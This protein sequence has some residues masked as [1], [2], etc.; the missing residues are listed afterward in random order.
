MRTTVA[1][2]LIGRHLA[3]LLH[4]GLRLLARFLGE[5]GLAD[6]LFEFVELVAAFFAFAELLLDRLELLVQ[7]I[8]ALRLLHLALDAASDLA[9]DLQHADLGF[10]QRE[11]ASPAARPCSAFRAAAW[12]S[13]IFTD[14]CEATVSASF[15]GSSICATEASVSAGTFL[16]SLM[17]CSKLVLTV[18]ISASVSLASPTLSGM[19]SIVAWKKS[20]ARHEAG[21]AGARLAF[22]QHAHGLVGQ[23]QKLQHGRQRADP[24]QAVGVGIV[25]GG[26]LLGQKQNLL[27]VVHHLFERANGFLAADEQRNDHVGKHDDIAQRQHRRQQAARLALSTTVTTS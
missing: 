5:L 10:D 21:D 16:L 22:D 18:R 9:L 23:L 11:H 4:F 27:L 6:A 1:S 13:A 17:Y 2:A 14:R 25:L 7:I 15:A 26:V 3:Q 8:L 20:R 12:R 24:M 19:R